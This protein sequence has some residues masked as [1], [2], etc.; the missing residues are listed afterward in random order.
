MITL[1]CKAV[2]S[3]DG[4]NFSGYQVQPG[5]RTIQ[6]EIEKALYTICKKDIKVV[7]SGRTDAGVHAM[8]QII[9]F[10]TE[11]QMENWQW[12]KAMNAL[13]PN[14]IQ[15]KEVSEVN[16]HFHARYDV[17]G[18]E[19]RYFVNNSEDIDIFRRDYEAHFK[20][21]INMGAMRQAADYVSGTQ[22]FSSFCASNTSVVDK[23]RTIE[24][25]DI[26]KQDD[27]IEFRFVG[28]GFLYNMVRILVGTLLE[29][30][31]GKR[32]PVEMKTILKACDRTKAGKTAPAQGLFLWNVWYDKK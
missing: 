1:R 14:D 18:K 4:S 31:S 21:E 24:R 17:I 8:G 2:L 23:V 7:A 25:I 32:N 22:D 19:Y 11:I 16:D 30:G 15:V 13:L 5:K 9:H 26:L 12:K 29:I 10:D 20:E 28:N 6:L 3:Y 27:R